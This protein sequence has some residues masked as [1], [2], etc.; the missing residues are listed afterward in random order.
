MTDEY[1][2]IVIVTDYVLSG[3]SGLGIYQEAEGH[4]SFGD[5]DCYTI[6]ELNQAGYEYQLLTYSAA[7]EYIARGQ[8]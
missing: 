3:G 6:A 4:Y 2:P 7:S 1:Y 5:G 8:K